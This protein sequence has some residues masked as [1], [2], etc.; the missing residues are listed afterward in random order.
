MMTTELLIGISACLMHPDPTRKAAA[1]KTLQFIEQSTAHWIMSGGA[2]PVMVPSPLGD[3]T[4]KQITCADYAQRLDGLVLH[5]GADVWPGSYGETALKPEWNGDALRDAYEI[6]LTHAFVRAGKP[7]FGVC[8]GL[9]LINVAF[10]GTLYQDLQTQVHGA[11]RHLDR[12]L[13]ERNLHSIDIVQGTKL[14]QLLGQPDNK[15]INSIHHQGVKDLA[16]NFVIEARCDQ[17]GVVEAIRY[18]ALPYVAAVQWH[19]ELH[20]PEH[21]VL[22]DSALLVDFLAAA[23]QRRAAHA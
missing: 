21:G 11:S 22:N 4:A 8:R 23:Q 5:G 6:E 13:Y 20:R 3:T 7:V 17:D 14:E 19:P 10:G 15:K 2:M 12:P 18:T 1:S 9:Q 16:P